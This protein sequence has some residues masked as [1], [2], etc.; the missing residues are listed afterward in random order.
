MLR[1]SP[2]TFGVL[3]SFA[4]FAGL[5]TLLLLAQRTI[6]D[7][8]P[9]AQEPLPTEIVGPSLVTSPEEPSSETGTTAPGS[10]VLT[11]PGGPLIVA[12]VGTSGPSGQVNEPGTNP[13]KEKKPG[14]QPGGEQ[15][16]PPADE[17]SPPP[18]QSPSPPGGP[19]EQPGGQPPSPPGVLPAST[20]GDEDDDDGQDDDDSDDTDGNGGAKDQDNGNGEN[21]ENE[22]K[23]GG[24]SKGKD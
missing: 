3:L 2:T 5:L 20:D 1:R 24:K 21:G 11:V 10:S 9:L 4:S 22:G 13:D 8:T 6:P 18:G 16:K 14:E 12:P 15:P 17:P 7:R 19:E 23:G